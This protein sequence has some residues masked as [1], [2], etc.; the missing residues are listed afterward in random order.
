MTTTAAAVAAGREGEI[1]GGY[2][3]DGDWCALPAT[4]RFTRRSHTLLF[5]GKSLEAGSSG[6]R[7]RLEAT[8]ASK[9]TTLPVF[10]KMHKVGGTTVA[11][12]LDCVSVK[13]A[14]LR[15]VVDSWGKGHPR[16][17]CPPTVTNGWRGPWS[18]VSLFSHTSS[19]LPTVRL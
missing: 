8:T 10:V 4:G 16:K 5:P 18:H 12:L 6:G 19:I 15:R 14:P 13:K 2:R 11:T 7:R 3:P 17:S 1:G 9:P